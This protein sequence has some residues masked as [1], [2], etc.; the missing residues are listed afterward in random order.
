MQKIF[1][2]FLEDRDEAFSNSIQVLKKAKNVK[3]ISNR[4]AALA[5]L[6]QAFYI[7]QKKMKMKSNL[8]AM[9]VLSYQAS[10]CGIDFGSFLF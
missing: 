6:I 2:Y 4:G 5:N 8:M 7:K 9:D 10:Q 3:M 1:V